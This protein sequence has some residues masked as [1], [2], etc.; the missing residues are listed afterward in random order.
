MK[1]KTRT[2]ALSWLLSLALVLS[3]VP[4]MS[5]TAYAAIPSV[6]ISPADSGTVSITTSSDSVYTYYHLTA[7]PAAGYYFKEWTY[8]YGGQTNRNSVNPTSWS[9][10]GLSKAS[11]LTAVFAEVIP[12]TGVQLNKTSVAMTVGAKETLTATV[13]PND[14]TYKNVTWSSDNSD[15][16]TAANGV[17]TAVGAG[18]ANITVTATNGT[19]DTSDDNTASCAVTVHAHSYTYALSSDGMSITATCTDTTAHTENYVATLTIGAPEEGFEAKI[20]DEGNIQ[21]AATVS[22]FN[23]DENGN[24]TGDALGSSPTE[25]GNYWAEITLG[26]GDN[27]ATAHVVYGVEAVASITEQNY[28]SLQAAIDAA[29]DG[30]TVKLLKNVKDRITFNKNGV[31]AT[32]DLNGHTIDGNQQGTVLTISSGTFILDDSSEGKT[33]VITNGTQGVAVNGGTFKM[34]GGTIEGNMGGVNGAGASVNS[35]AAFEMTGG[36]IQYNSTTSYT[37]GILLNGGSNFIMSGGVIQYNNG[38]NNGF[39]GL[40]IAGVQPKFSGTAVVKGNVMG[41]TITKTETGYTLTGGTPCDVR[42]TDRTAKIEIA[43]ALQAGAQIGVYNYISI[44]AFTTGYNT[45]HAGDAADK[46][47]FSNDAKKEIGKNTS[48]ELM[49]VNHVHN[50]T[51]SVDGTSI[52]AT[53]Q[54]VNCTLENRTASLTIAPSSSGGY[55]ATL[56]GDKTTF[57]VTDSNIEY[58]SNDGANW[59]TTVPTSVGSYQARF[60]VTDATDN[61]KTY[62]ATVSYGVNA[63]TMAKEY[64]EAEDHGTV[65]APAVA[66]SGATITL[67]VTPA[68]GYQI[69]TVKYNETTITPSEGVYK[70]TMPA[71]DVTVSATFVGKDVSATLSVTGNSGTSCTASMLNSDFT[72]ITGPLSKKAG[73]KFILSVSTDEDYDYTV[74]FSPAQSGDLK[75]Y[76]TEFSAAEYTAY[77]SYIQA[78]KISVP[79]QTDLFW[80]TMPGVNSDSLTTTVTFA[81]SKTFT[82]LYQPTG[83]SPSEVW[84][85]FMKETGG[86]ETPFAVEMKKDAVMGDTAVWSAKVT[87]AFNPTKVAF[88]TST[89]ALENAAMAAATVSPSVAWTDIAG[90]KYLI[91]GNGAKTAI[92]AFVADSNAVAD[93]NSDTATLT[94]PTSNTGVTYLIA[95]CGTD[96]SGNVTTAGAVTAPTAPTAPTGKEFDGWRGFSGDAP[97]KTE[98]KYSA[99]DSISIKENTIFNAVWKPA[100]LSVTLNPNGGTGGSDSASVTYGETLAITENPTRENYVFNGW[101]VSKAVAENGVFFARGSSFDLSTPITANL[102]L[103]AQWKHIHSYTP[104]QISDPVFNGKLDDMLGYAKACHIILCGCKE[105]HAEAHS[106][107]SSGKCACGYQKPTP[108]VTLNVSYGQWGNNGYTARVTE[109]PQTATKDSEV[110]VSAPSTWGTLKFSRWQYS[111]NGTTWK[112][113][114]AYLNVS[115]I[116]PCNMQVRALYVNPTTNPEVNMSATTYPVKDSASGYTFDSILFQMNYKLPDGYTYVDSGVRA[117]DNEGISYYELKERKR[118][119]GEKAAWGAL[120]FGANLLSGSLGDAFFAGAYSAATLDSN[121][122]YEKREN[123]VLSE[124]SAATLGSYMYQN[125]PVNVE[126]YPPIYWDYKPNTVSYSGSINALIPVRFAQKNN[127]NHYIYG[128]AW[129]RYRKPNGAIETIY[130]PALA[131]TLKGVGS[132]VTVTK[133]GS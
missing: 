74:A 121:F 18:T 19:A 22:Y 25:V 38:G 44:G 59:S 72:A 101:T 106:F 69:G 115:F 128:I 65:T 76:I 127:Q 103:R 23:V 75:N 63:I 36:T 56:S 29:A 45:Y 43:G 49:F 35:Y 117:G 96:G 97:S 1:H 62:S 95:V 8:V 78:H 67:T 32:L 66:G 98:T 42:N 94:V 46:F 60:T 71:E 81:K 61:T 86:T 92:A 31:T 11:N 70:F 47:F 129:L 7:S 13:L 85:K 57:G 4:G 83:G 80:V 54:K 55:G 84:C 15:V 112:D 90:G 3:L 37:G 109:F 40:G 116:I 118:T 125:K 53:C 21:G 114:A 120:N 131:T 48:G 20:T 133:S 50:F 104:Y 124:M 2:K 130:T 99:G 9:A 24:K 68:T 122:Y 28:T 6:A 26:T 105:M 73:E 102:E 5:L 33:G 107:D 110:S 126:K 39:G 111:T 52:T 82:V 51:Y 119:A 27:T 41:G 91:V 17:V 34:N 12:A 108:T 58:S 79:S 16:A 87:A 132:S 123:S 64:T 113:L 88:V 100:T 10:D 14:A 30:Q 93:Y 89:S 77:A